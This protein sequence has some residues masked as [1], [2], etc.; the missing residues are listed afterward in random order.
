M[1]DHQIYSRI[2][3]FEFVY[4]FLC[5]VNVNKYIKWFVVS[6]YLW[7]FFIRVNIFVFSDLYSFCSKAFVTATRILRIPY[8]NCWY[9][10]ENLN[11]VLSPKRPHVCFWTPTIHENSHDPG[12]SIGSKPRIILINRRFFEFNDRTVWRR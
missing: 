3:F 2:Y 8:R 9:L 6:R 12:L 10:P 4:L 7:S 5:T 11:T 1:C